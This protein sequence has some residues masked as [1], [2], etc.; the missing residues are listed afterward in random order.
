VL[1]SDGRT[2]YAALPG[3]LVARIDCATLATLDSTSLGA[4]ATALSM[5]LKLR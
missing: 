2:L 1:G 3:G 4:D 5:R